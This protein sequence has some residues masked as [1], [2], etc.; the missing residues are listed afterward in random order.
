MTPGDHIVATD[1]LHTH[2][3][4]YLG[5]NRVV[6]YGSDD[7]KRFARVEIVTEDA[8][9]QGRL[10][11]VLDTP[12]TF[13][14]DEICRRAESRLGE[15]D[16]SLFDNNCEH[17]VS[18]CRSGLHASR[19][20][21]RVIERTTSA[22]T[23]VMARVVA[24]AISKAATKQGGKFIAKA[25]ARCASGWLIAADAAQLGAEI[26]MSQYGAKPRQAENAGQA[27]GLAASV[28]IGGVVAGPVGAA[29]GGALWLVGE[30][31]GKRTTS[32]SA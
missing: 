22:G 15:Q 2:H 19:Q 14:S 10:V 31:A 16:Y 27:V 5:S 21:D 9:A 3:G 11:Y 26:A 4:I 12:T 17:F 20:V 28:G 18:W 1:T 8:F 7:D 30:L 13:S 23:K 25:F 32:V 29:S 6:Q 24:K